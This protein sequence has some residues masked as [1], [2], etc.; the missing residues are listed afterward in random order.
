MTKNNKGLTMIELLAAIV[1]LSILLMIAVPAISDTINKTKK[2]TYVSDA[3]K[4][5]SNADYQFRK[6]NKVVKPTKTRCVLMSLVYLDNGVF[7]EA[8]YGGSYVRN[9]SFVVAVRDDSNNIIYYARLV[10]DIGDNEFMGINYATSA[11]L[12]ADGS[13]DL[14][15]NFGVSELFGVNGTDNATILNAVKTKVPRCSTIEVYAPNSS[16]A[17]EDL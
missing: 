12:E 15:Y 8:P 9:K 14:V 3:L 6:D 11:Q 13:Y 4:L 10:E 7:D 1:I 2:K 16:D 17:Q 5:I